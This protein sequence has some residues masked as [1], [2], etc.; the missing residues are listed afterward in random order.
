MTTLWEPT[1]RKKKKRKSLIFPISFLHC[2]GIRGEGL[3]RLPGVWVWQSLTSPCLLGNVVRWCNNIWKIFHWLLERSEHFAIERRGDTSVSLTCSR[4]FITGCFKISESLWESRK[5]D[6]WKHERR[7]L[8]DVSGRGKEQ[9]VLLLC[10]IS[11]FQS[12]KPSRSK[13]FPKLHFLFMAGI[14]SLQHVK[15]PL[16]L[17]ISSSSVSVFTLHSLNNVSDLC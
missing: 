11:G 17:I 9:L 4:L 15:K 7:V 2:E 13:Y 16:L 14:F 5:R 6:I 10:S 8:T 3:L 1:N 12:L